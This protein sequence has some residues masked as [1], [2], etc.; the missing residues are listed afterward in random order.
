MTVL[1]R[2]PKEPRSWPAIG[3]E[4]RGSG[5]A[6]WLVDP[7][8]PDSVSSTLERVSRGER[9]ARPPARGSSMPG[10]STWEQAAERVERLYQG[11]LEA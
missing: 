5:G 7:D 1:E 2:S 4:F 9:S 8:E 6:A 3:E 11:I 10:S